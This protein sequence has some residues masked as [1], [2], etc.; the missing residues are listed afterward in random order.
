MKRCF[1][2][3]LFLVGSLASLVMLLSPSSSSIAEAQERKT[4][5]AEPAANLVLGTVASERG[6]TATIPLYY[7]PGKNTRLRS[8][9]LELD[10]VS[11]SVKFIKAEKGVAAAVQDYDLSFDAKELPPDDKKITHTRI[12]IGISLPDAETKKSLPE[13]LWVFLNF[14][15]PPEAK[16][17]SIALNPI[18]IS[19]QDLARKP[20]EVAGEAGKIIVSVPDEPLAGCFFFSH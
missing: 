18:S 3:P 11:N 9:H 15:I 16:P 6:T 4:S 8:L 20:V 19:A 2:L 12:N 10:F 13:G 1:N 17:F 14:N 7:Q 5:A